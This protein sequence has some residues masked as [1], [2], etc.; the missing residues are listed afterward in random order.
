MY[1]LILLGFLMM[2]VVATGMVM[3]SCSAPSSHPVDKV[4]SSADSGIV[5]LPDGATMLAR[6]GTV[7][8][9]LVDWLATKAHSR[10]FELG[11]QEFVGRS[12]APTIESKAR[13]PRLI[14]ML[15][16]HPEVSIAI[17]GHCDRTD[18]P[19]ADQRLSEARARSV[20]DMLEAGGIAKDRIAVEGRGGAQPIAGDR[21]A[22]DRARDERVSIVLTRRS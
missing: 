13:L 1:R 10:A 15:K 8:R 6:P 11:G 5:A 2:L 18:D 7:G 14:A 22:E 4:A 16:A 9:D 17:V 20:A 19:A 21:T 3:K 12:P